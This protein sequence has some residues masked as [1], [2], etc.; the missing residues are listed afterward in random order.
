MKEP[1]NTR[2]LGQYGLVVLG[3]GLLMLAG[4]LFAPLGP[5]SGTPVR[6]LA[7]VLTGAASLGLLFSAGVQ[8]P[9]RAADW[10][11]R[12][13]WLRLLMLILTLALALGSLVGLAGMTQLVLT[14]PPAR[15]YFT[16]I[17]SLTDVEA[18]L[19]VSGH[20]PYTSGVAAYRSALS[21]FPLALATPVRGPVFGT[22]YTEP[23]ISRMETIQ[24]QYVTAP[25]QV[26]G[27]FDPR[28]LHSYP[29]L[30][31]LLYVPL[32]WAGGTNIL[33]VHLLVYWVVFAWLIWLAP[34]G[35]RH[36]GALVTL[37]AMPAVMAS[38]IESDEVICIA[39][40][41]LA[42]HLRERRWMG[43][44][45]LGLACAFKQYAWFFVPF[46]AL[47]VVLGQGWRAGLRWAGT[48]MAAFLLPNLPFLLA[49]P[50]AWLVS[51]GIPMTDPFFASGMGLVQLSTSHVLPYVPPVSYALLEVAAMSTGLWIFAR[52][53]KEVG[54]NVLVLALLPLFFAF[55]CTP[56]YFAFAPWLALYAV[57]VRC[58]VGMNPRSSPVVQAAARALHTASLIVREA[59]L[60]VHRWQ[61]APPELALVLMNLFLYVCE[62]FSEHLFASVA[63]DGPAQKHIHARVVFPPEIVEFG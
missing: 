48:G 36:W 17:V 20:N 42:W 63:V 46:F 55:R 39:L 31:F 57:N 4:A 10:L 21:R 2:L 6:G 16:D 25:E 12:C 24:R 33:L 58:R 52:S 62:Y 29:A 5:E 23:S 41:L 1:Q 60:Q 11:R 22:S 54:A 3:S 14:A 18:E 26:P 49:S 32:L 44:V 38:L 15:S 61:L 9:S 35:W 30:S 59:D 37:A 7:T 27:A 13:V 47:E 40:I 53:R 43:A 45:L 19:V 28:T 8:S 50:E 34:V 56:N 51:L